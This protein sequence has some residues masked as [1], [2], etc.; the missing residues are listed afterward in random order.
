MKT[1]DEILKEVMGDNYAL[2]TKEHITNSDVQEMLEEAIALKNAEFLEFLKAI[3]KWRS[4]DRMSL[5]AQEN[6]KNK[7]KELEK[8]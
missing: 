7:I 1:D 6:I 2:E 5:F 8:K 4:W 3:T